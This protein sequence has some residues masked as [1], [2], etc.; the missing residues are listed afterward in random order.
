[1]SKAERMLG[2]ASS[3][4]GIVP[5]PKSRVKSK[6]ER[7]LGAGS[8]EARAAPRSTMS[9]AERMLGASA[10][11]GTVGG[12]CATAV[13]KKKM[14]KA[15]RMMG[16][17]DPGCDT[18]KAA[19]TNSAPK[20]Q[21][22]DTAQRGQLR[23]AMARK[24]YSVDV[25][26]PATF[27]PETSPLGRALS[28]AAI[29]FRKAS[30]SGGERARSDSLSSTDSTQSSASGSSLGRR[31]QSMLA[32][33]SPASRAREHARSASESSTDSNRSSLSQRRG[34]AR[35]L[36]TVDSGAQLLKGAPPAAGGG[37]GK[38]TGKARG[39]APKLPMKRAVRERVE[40]ALASSSGSGSSRAILGKDA[41]A[42]RAKKDA[43]KDTAQ[44]GRQS[45]A[46]ARRAVTKQKLVE[47]RAAAAKAK[48]EAEAR[49]LAVQLELEALDRAAEE[50]M[51]ALEAEEEADAFQEELE[52]E[53]DVLWVEDSSGESSSSS[54]VRSSLLL[55]ARLFFSL[56][57]YSF[58][59]TVLLLLHLAQDSGDDVSG[60]E[61]DTLVG[62]A[63][64][65]HGLMVR[66]PSLA[67]IA[68]AAGAPKPAAP[69]RSALQRRR[70]MA[71]AATGSTPRGS[72]SDVR[73]EAA[74]APAIDFDQLP[75]NDC[76]P[77]LAGSSPRS[78]GSRRSE[79]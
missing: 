35:S 21:R 27:S 32:L 13:P 53:C 26:L 60:D 10:A 69:P 2:A 1:M 63:V 54:G 12:I 16:A 20:M 24:K 67:A 34:D 50:D 17:A 44:A 15:E 7:M 65:T 3:S 62:D 39:P 29:N 59:C 9:K 42:R 56:L 28:V 79:Q 66:K 72:I 37:Q 45:A 49:F 70:S 31:A 36:L 73:A 71:I 61:F 41:R 51:A 78:V 6:A 58:V 14:S 8:V 11:P 22:I 77:R 47:A 30:F 4:G 38:R 64:P 75:T 74:S 40:A 33:L 46:A 55:F 25:D 48:E 19:R 52:E 23:S 57:I 5:R 43:K 76:S 18:R 68:A